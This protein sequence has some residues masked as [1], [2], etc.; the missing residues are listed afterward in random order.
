MNLHEYNAILHLNNLLVLLAKIKNHVT[1]TER[2]HTNICI[3]KNS[4]YIHH[5][6]YS[7]VKY[8]NKMH[9]N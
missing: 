9:K 2:R 8:E 5:G 7:S 1:Y 3:I 4:E 6:Y